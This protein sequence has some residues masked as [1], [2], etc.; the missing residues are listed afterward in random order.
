[1]FIKHVPL[2][3][4]PDGFVIHTEL[5]G[6]IVRH[7]GSK[8]RFGYLDLK[9]AFCHVPSAAFDDFELSRDQ[10]EFLFKVE[11]DITGGEC[12]SEFA[13][14]VDAFSSALLSGVDGACSKQ[15]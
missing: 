7:T 4:T 5:P 3:A 10:T 8:N 2:E 9:S 1:L 12:D 14:R 15:D 6:D 13:E 11:G